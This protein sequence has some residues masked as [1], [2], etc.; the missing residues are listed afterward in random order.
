MKLSGGL[1]SLLILVNLGLAYP[2]GRWDVPK[3]LR[4]HPRCPPPS[5]FYPVHGLLEPGCPESEAPLQ[6]RPRQR[7]GQRDAAFARVLG[8]A[9]LLMQPRAAPALPAALSHCGPP[10][11]SPSTTPPPG[12]RAAKPGPPPIP[13][14]T[15]PPWMQGP[16]LLPVSKAASSL[17][18]HL[19]LPSQPA[20]VGDG[21]ASPLW[22]AHN[23]DARPR[24]PKDSHRLGSRAASLRPG[25][26]EG[27]RSGRCGPRRPGGVPGQVGRG[28]GQGWGGSLAPGLPLAAEAGPGV[29]RR[30]A[31][32]PRA[33]AA[34]CPAPDG[35][36]APRRASP[37]GAS[38]AAAAAEMPAGANASC[39]DCRVPR[40]ARHA[41][42]AVL[43]VTIVVDLLGNVL[44]ILAVLRNR[45]LRN[46][47][48]IF[49]VSLSVADLVVAVYP[50]PLTLAAIFRNEWTMGP[51]HC[52]ISG[53][54][55]GLS[56]VGSIFNI[57]AVAIN[58]YCYICH[59]LRYDKLFNLK[60]TYGYL[61]LTWLLT[62]VATVPN[63]FV[64]SLQYDHRIY[65][66]TFAQSVSASYTIA[67]VAVHFIIPLSIVTFC[68]LRIWILVFQ[69]KHRVRQ[70]GKQKVRAADI[71]NFLTMFVVFV[72]FAVCWGPLNLIG[73]AVSINPSKIIPQIPEWLFVVSYFMAYFNSCL[74]AVIYGLLNQNFR[75]E[76]KQIL[77]SLWVPRLL[78]VDASKGGTEGM[79]SKP[80]PAATNHHHHQAELYL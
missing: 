64:G 42:A 25:G 68:Y 27:G 52:Q 24:P 15:S 31:Q 47:G 78:F 75:K 29:R 21:Q 13:A 77:L 23:F 58:R 61:C 63:F 30:A 73:L 18:A 40:E 17:S 57:T 32:A 34:L 14:C 28:A 19:R 72:L 53:F 7:P 54:L 35:A 44:A 79:K 80:S 41:L 39:P 11:S 70:D 55:M 8:A 20:L 49:V 4:R 9:L 10:P 51:V 12:C 43:I 71:R 76:Y 26:E 74:N 46:A 60:N 56:V 33:R 45:K 1:K 38:A 2:F 16:A 66:C 65:S 5:L 59:S 36:G 37:A 62:L 22:V 48:N 67:V 50:Y 6:G 69:V 3:S